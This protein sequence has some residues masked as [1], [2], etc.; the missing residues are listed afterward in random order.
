MER[1]KISH[2]NYS[3]KAGTKFSILLKCFHHSLFYYQRIVSLPFEGKV[4]LDDRGSW[5]ALF[6]II[7]SY[8][9]NFYVYSLL[10][11]FW[12]FFSG[13]A[14]GTL[15]TTHTLVSTQI[16]NTGNSSDHCWRTIKGIPTVSFWRLACQE[17]PKS[18][19]VLYLSI[20]GPENLTVPGWN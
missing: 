9:E 16:I 11:E 2:I 18:K 3:L 4:Y 1:E 10:R 14:P 8:L 12:I 15:L 5:K 19:T 7:K 13:T 17:T 20:S 6:Q